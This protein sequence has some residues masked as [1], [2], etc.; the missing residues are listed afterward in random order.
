MSEHS[1]KT[2]QSM[3]VSLRGLAA[4]AG[5]APVWATGGPVG[6]SGRSVANRAQAGRA[7]GLEFG[8]GI[9]DCRRMCGRH[10]RYVPYLLQKRR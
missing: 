5:G 4:G 9:D 1:T 3:S 10:L 2:S 6:V 8:G 7:Q